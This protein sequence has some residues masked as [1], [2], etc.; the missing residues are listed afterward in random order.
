[1]LK[2][3]LKE[4]EIARTS[5]EMPLQSL[6]GAYESPDQVGALLK[7]CSL[8]ETKSVLRSESLILPRTYDVSR[9]CLI[10]TCAPTWLSRWSAN[11][12]SG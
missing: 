10:L 7:L 5:M 6:Y 11:S 12:M 8:W 3:A 1:M 4:V 2:R 9:L